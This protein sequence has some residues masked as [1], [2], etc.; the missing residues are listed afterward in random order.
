MYSVVRNPISYSF[1]I[2]ACIFLVISFGESLALVAQ[3]VF[4]PYTVDVSRGIG[5]I[6]AMF[7]RVLVFVSQLL[8]GLLVYMVSKLP[9]SSKRS[10]CSVVGIFFVIVYFLSVTVGYISPRLH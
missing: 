10:L 9:A 6:A 4:L 3:H 1:Y 7:F 5:D 2:F 8:T